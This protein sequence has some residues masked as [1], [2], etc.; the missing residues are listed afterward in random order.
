MAWKDVNVGLSPR[1][2]NPS[3]PLA[4]RSTLKILHALRVGEIPDLVAVF[5]ED[6]LRLSRR[7][8]P[9]TS[10]QLAL[11]LPGRP[12]GVAEGDQ[13]LLRAVLADD[14]AQH[15]AIGGHRQAGVDVDG[16]G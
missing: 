14:V 2:R 15:V 16:S 5:L 9:V 7:D 10:R 13:A 1:G 11:E 8:H 4:P 3:Y 6:Q 12:A